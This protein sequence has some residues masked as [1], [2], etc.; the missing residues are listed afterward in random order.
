MM[1]LDLQITTAAVTTTPDGFV[2][3]VFQVDPHPLPY[4]CVLHMHIISCALLAS[5]TACSYSVNSSLGCKTMPVAIWP[6]LSPQV[7]EIASANS[8]VFLVLRVSSA[9]QPVTLAQ[10]KAPTGQ[11]YSEEEIQCH[12]HFALYPSS[13]RE[14]HLGDKRQRMRDE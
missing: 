14:P 5:L 1:R 3:D 12:V 8:C 2:Y 7:F 9:V 6:R 11:E 10:V 13:S 4:L